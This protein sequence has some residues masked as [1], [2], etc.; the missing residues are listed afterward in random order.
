MSQPR[1]FL[2]SSSLPSAKSFR[3]HMRSDRGIGS[4]GKR[5]RP[6]RCIAKGTAA[7]ALSLLE[8]E[9]RATVIVS[10]MYTSALPK[11]S[12]GTSTIIDLA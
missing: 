4:L 7:D 1:V 9:C 5:G 3:R 8:V 12:S 11:V 2:I 10:S 6:I